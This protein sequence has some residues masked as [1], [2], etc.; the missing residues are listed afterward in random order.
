MQ[1]MRP[2]SRI[3]AVDARLI[4]PSTELIVVGW[5]IGDGDNDRIAVCPRSDKLPHRQLAK[6]AG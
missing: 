2:E 3:S 6:D 5:S 1:Q 4:F